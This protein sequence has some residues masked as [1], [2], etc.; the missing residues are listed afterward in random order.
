MFVEYP[1]PPPPIHQHTNTGDC[2]WLCVHS[3]YAA[4]V[5]RTL[6]LHLSLVLVVPL[7]EGRY[8][9]R[10]RERQAVGSHRK[11]QSNLVL[12]CS[13]LEDS[14]G[15]QTAQGRQRPAPILL[16]A[17]PPRS[18]RPQGREVS[19]AMMCLGGLPQRTEPVVGL[20]H[21]GE[22][23]ADWWGAELRGQIRGVPVMVQRKWIWLGTMRLRVWSLAS[24]SG[25]KICI[26]V[27]CGVV[28]DVARI[29]HC[30]GC[31]VGRQQQLPLDP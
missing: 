28:Q 22:P 19:R 25:L 14:G 3:A 17:H 16:W 30:C 11:G 31:G 26:A 20:K 23:S 24:I 18:V 9:E 12:P 13:L 21:H 8:K 6:L 5:V 7:T 15:D 1:P 10:R 27:S 2:Q 4:P 29:W